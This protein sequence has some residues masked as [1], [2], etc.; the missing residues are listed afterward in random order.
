[1]VSEKFHHA[2]SFCELYSLA[3]CE[4][5]LVNTICG[6]VHFSRRLETETLVTSVRCST[7]CHLEMT[8][9]FSRSMRT[10]DS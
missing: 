2:S 10:Q 6:N 8:V 9:A 1:M 3:N 5:W 4:V 7:E